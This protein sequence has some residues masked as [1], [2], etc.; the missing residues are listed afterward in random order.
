MKRKNRFSVANSIPCCV[1]ADI[2]LFS[3]M[4]DAS[5][6]DALV[7]FA[8]QNDNIRVTVD[9]SWP[10]S[11]TKAVALTL[12]GAATFGPLGVVGA[13]FGTLAGAVVG[14]GLAYATRMHVVSACAALVSLA[15]HERADVCRA[16]AAAPA[17]FLDAKGLVAILRKARLPNVSAIEIVVDVKHTM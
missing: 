6:F 9:A 15:S 5:S 7:A 1:C 16:A 4:A 10:Q 17:G 14:V 2:F 12:L 8:S 11:V 13:V 3:Q